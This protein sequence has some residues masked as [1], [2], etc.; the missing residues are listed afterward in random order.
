MENGVALP[1]PIDQI[2]GG[3]CFSFF[4]TDLIMD[5]PQRPFIPTKPTRADVAYGPPGDIELQGS[6]AALPNFISCVT[7]LPHA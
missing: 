7:L 6:K 1:T 2:V 5:L 3:V 4:P